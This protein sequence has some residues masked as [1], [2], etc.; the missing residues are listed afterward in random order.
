[1]GGYS[2]VM[3]VGPHVKA[4]DVEIDSRESGGSAGFEPTNFGLRRAMVAS[5]STE[6]T[7]S[8]RGG[9]SG[10]SDGLVHTGSGQGLSS[11]GSPR[12]PRTSHINGHTASMPYRPRTTHG[13]HVNKAPSALQFLPVARPPSG[14]TT[15][16]RSGLAGASHADGF[17]GDMQ[18]VRGRHREIRLLKPDDTSG[19]VMENLYLLHTRSP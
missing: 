12:A 19:P 6:D 18:L 15:L 7:E 2:P 9:M 16:I 10:G 14:L 5:V 8:G 3:R 17:K 13:Y 4:R 1:M 11:R